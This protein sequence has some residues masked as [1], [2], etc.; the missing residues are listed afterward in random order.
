[1]FKHAAAGARRRW[2]VLLLSLV[3][4]SALALSG[5]ALLANASSRRAAADFT[6]SNLKLAKLDVVMHP[7]LNPPEC[8]TPGLNGVPGMVKNFTVGGGVSRPALVSFAGDFTIG[9]NSSIDFSVFIDGSQ[10]SNNF[11]MSTSG[12]QGARPVSLTV[13]TPSPLALGT[14]T[15]A[16]KWNQGLGPPVC[17]ESELTMTIQH[18]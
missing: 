17:T 3:S 5:F 6:Y 7:F 13:P 8:T 10:V 16:I 1:M 9:A 12:D 15:A 14:H 11:T 2:P 18:G 4:V